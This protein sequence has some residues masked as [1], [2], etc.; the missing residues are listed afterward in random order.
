M[1]I[2][3]G[4]VGR[5]FAAAF[6]AAGVTVVPVTRAA[7]WDRAADASDPAPRVVCVREEQLEDVLGRLPVAT[8][9][10]TALIQNGFLEVVHGDLGPV[11]RGVVYFTAKGDFFKVLAPSPFH[12]AH[13]GP[14]AAALA[15]G[16]IPAQEVPGREAFLRAMIAKC[17]WNCVVGLP[18]HVRE[19][20]LRTYLGHLRPELTA[21]A[22]ECA[23]TAAAEYGVT[24]DVE[25]GIAQLEATTRELGWMRGGAKAI[26]WRNGAVAAMGR[27]HGIPTP[28][29]D[30]LLA[31]I[32]YEATSVSPP[33]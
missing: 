24:I 20:D 11:T 30:R 12:G 10:N 33:A 6:E 8:R 16:G 22:E 28:V 13:A 15:R 7:G 14:L 25:A 31:S 18:L 32:G 5:R 4:E 29:T 19:I 2:G 26:P 1:V 3:L 21:L 9:A 27:K 17:V 23:S